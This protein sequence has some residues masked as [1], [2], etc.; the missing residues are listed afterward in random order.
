MTKRSIK[1]RNVSHDGETMTLVEWSKRTGLSYLTIHM[2]LKAGWP[3]ERALNPK[4]DARGRRR[5]QPFTPTL[6]THLPALLDYH[7]DMQAAHRQMT[8]SIRAFVRGMEA[9]MAELRY[10]LEKNLAAQTEQACREALNGFTTPGV[11]ENIS[12]HPCD[13]GTSRAQDRT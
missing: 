8:R 1:D 2:R 4:L 12:N 13:R 11:V 9:Q 7:R 3:V 6:A 10:Q 5:K